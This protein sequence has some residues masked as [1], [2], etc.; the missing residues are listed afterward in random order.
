M[1]PL[2]LE[3]L[4]YPNDLALRSR[5]NSNIHDKA[6]WLNVL[7]KQLGLI[8]SNTKTDLIALKTSNRRLVQVENEDLCM[9]KFAYLNC[10]T[11]KDGE[12]DL[13]IQS[14]LRNLRSPLNMI[15]KVW[16]SSTYSI[17]TKVKLYHTCVITILLYGLEC[18]W[19][20]EKDLIK[21]STFHT[22]SRTV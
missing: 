13:D 3:D 20:A 1:D 4:D 14:R 5:T 11:N 19:F 7:A 15:R 2:L 9:G 22:I 8:I 6:R 10:I 16:R 18:P 12:A 17:C 21:L